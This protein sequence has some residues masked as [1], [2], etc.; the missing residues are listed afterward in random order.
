MPAL[1]ADDMAD[2][3][4]ALMRAATACFAR[5]GYRATSMRDICKEAG[6][7]I[8]GLYC[9][10]ASKEEILISI[11]EQPHG[12][13]D[14]TFAQARRAVEDGRPAQA[15]SCDVLRTMLSFLEREGGR[16]MLHGDIA[17]MGEAVTMPSVR[18]LLARTDRRHMEKFAALLGADLA[19]EDA[20][21]QA[22]LLVAA[23]YGLMVLSAYHETFDPRACIDALEGLFATSQKRGTHP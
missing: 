21:T 8:G 13:I 2:R 12:E 20:E 11:A 23:L 6:V 18:T 3:R 10:F 1:S 15:A 4:T 17:I 5:K 22:Q 19:P 14:E 7:S 9:H 16:D